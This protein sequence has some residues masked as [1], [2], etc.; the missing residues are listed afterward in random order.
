MRRPCVKCFGVVGVAAIVSVVSFL[1]PEP[2]FSGEDVVSDE[3]AGV[4]FA[5]TT[6]GN[7]AKPDV[8]HDHDKHRGKGKHDEDGL[9]GHP[10]VYVDYDFKDF[11]GDDFFEEFEEML[12][13]MERMQQRMDRFYDHYH[14]RR[15]SDPNRWK[16]RHFQ[17]D[18]TKWYGPWHDFDRSDSGIRADV[19]DSGTAYV[20]RCEV[21]V[22]DRKL[23][24]E[25]KIKSTYKDGVLTIILP[26]AAPKKKPVP[27]KNP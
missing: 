12:K 17:D 1:C 11:S 24:E 9:F 21:S 5:P 19:H 15:Q 25:D 10:K 18:D 3:R 6:N 8:S 7:R 14:Q 23:I 27:V 13:Q 26:K 16:F 4:W 2:A 22:M 20:V